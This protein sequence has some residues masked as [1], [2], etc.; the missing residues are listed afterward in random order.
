MNY[1]S[2]L[3]QLYQPELSGLAQ[4]TWSL[5]PTAKIKPIMPVWFDDVVSKRGKGMLNIMHNASYP[6]VVFPEFVPYYSVVA[7]HRQKRKRKPVQLKELQ[8][9]Y[10]QGVEALDVD[11]LVQRAISVI[12]NRWLKQNGG[13]MKLVDDN[14][15][16]FMFPSEMLPN[17]LQALGMPKEDMIKYSWV[18]KEE[19][20]WSK[21]GFV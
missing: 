11:M 4:A 2:N 12:C 8:L 5:S 16:I 18:K 7:F 6:W 17:I 3:D 14:F 19:I 13:I 21:T 1:T 20:D 15:I 10:F 9:R